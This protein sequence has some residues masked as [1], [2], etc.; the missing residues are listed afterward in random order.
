ME[1]DDDAGFAAWRLLSVLLS[2]L[3][4]EHVLSLAKALQMAE[5][6]VGEF[7]LEQRW[8]AK[9]LAVEL[10]DQLADQPPNA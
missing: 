10:R 4:K 2:T 1:M 3:V 7:H 6:L 5:S 9:A 8:A